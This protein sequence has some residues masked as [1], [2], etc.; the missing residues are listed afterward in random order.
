[1]LRW[2]HPPGAETAPER[3]PTRPSLRTRLLLSLVAAVWGGAISY[4]MLSQPHFY[5]DFFYPWSAA[6]IFLSGGSPYHA[7]RGGQYPY[8]TPFAYPLPAVLLVLPLASLGY[9]AAGALFFSVSSALLAFA[10]TRDGYHYLPIFA[11]APFLGA[12]SQAQWSPL[13]IAAALLP[14]L[15]FLAVCKPN[16]GL[17]L[18]ARKPSRSI[19]LG[20][21]AVLAA[22][23]LLRPSWPG[24]WLA[25]LG[26]L[27]LHPP[28]VMTP[29]GAVM[30][31]ALLRWRRPEARLVAAMACVPQL[32]FWSDQLPLLLV[33]RNLRQSLWCCILSSASV[34]V[35]TFLSQRPGSATQTHGG[36]SDGLVRYAGTP[37]LLG[38]YLPA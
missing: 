17:A 26:L 25:N 3:E 24:E 28:P 29:L 38:V 6:R 16:L 5:G 34:G 8:M 9:A 22:T 27:R 18:A 15:G 36:I 7:I 4:V 32:L 1:M 23:V 2:P 33:P 31:L 37:V 30:L 13:V 20:G 19:V 35:A 14:G 21:A 10:L 11:S 12:A